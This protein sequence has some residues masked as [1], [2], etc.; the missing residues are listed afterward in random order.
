MSNLRL[1]SAIELPA[2]LQEDLAAA[3]KDLHKLYPESRLA[4]SEGLHITLHFLSSQPEER[5]P[6]IYQ[7]F[8]EATRQTPRFQLEL[9]GWGAFS[10]WQKPRVVVAQYAS[11]PVLDQ[12]FA[13]IQTNL[14]PLGVPPEER[15]FLPHVTLARFRSRPVRQIAPEQELQVRDRTLPVGSIAL[16]QSKVGKGGSEYSVL[17]RWPLLP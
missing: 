10:S 8:E 14:V 2:A 1:F 3:Q 7:I 13:A 15:A 12:L 11:V 9:K 6:E 4:R 16:F 17:Q 5:L